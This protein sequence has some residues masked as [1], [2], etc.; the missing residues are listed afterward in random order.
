MAKSSA[1]EVI[2][3]NF[4]HQFWLNRLP[5]HGV[6]VLQRLSP[7]GA[8]PVKPGGFTIVSNFFVN[9]CRSSLRIEEVKPT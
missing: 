5:L 3:L 8:L 9:C 6:L 1:G 7:P 4:G 2:E